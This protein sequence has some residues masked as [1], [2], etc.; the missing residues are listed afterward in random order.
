M[1]NS[2]RSGWP[3]TWPDTRPI[4]ERCERYACA[5]RAWPGV[6]RYAVPGV[7]NH[8]CCCASP[9]RSGRLASRRCTRP[10]RRYT[11]RAVRCSS[12]EPDRC[13]ARWHR[14][15]RPDTRRVV[16]ATSAGASS[17]GTQ[18]SV[19]QDLRRQLISRVANVT[20]PVRLCPAPAGAPR[21]AVPRRLPPG[22]ARFP[23]GPH[24]A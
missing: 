5:T 19:G 21:F 8:A 2:C 9:W 4:M 15:A 10:R 13:L 16:R 3:V 1:A 12:C 24:A 6:H 22:T 11:W 20:A 18:R 23:P 7:A 17:T 14:T